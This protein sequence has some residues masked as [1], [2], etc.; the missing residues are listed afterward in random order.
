MT[1]VFIPIGLIVDLATG[2]IYKRSEPRPDLEIDA[3]EDTLST[4]S[5][6]VDF[7][8]DFDTGLPEPT[9]ED[10]PPELEPPNEEP[11]VE[12]N[13]LGGAPVLAVSVALCARAPLWPWSS[14]PEAMEG[15]V[16]AFATHMQ[17]CSACV[18]AL[19][20][21]A[22]RDRRAFAV[23]PAVRLRKREVRLSA[24]ASSGLDP[25]RVMKLGRSAR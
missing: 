10:A 2:A 13:E 3:L 19:V 18:A 5:E 12:P 4:D 25:A 14:G 21:P 17:D 15:F 8:V 1:S 20:E 7:D 24:H 9:P 6:P 23:R 11:P 22:P 16:A